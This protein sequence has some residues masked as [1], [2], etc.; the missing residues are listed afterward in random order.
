MSDGYYV[1]AIDPGEV[2]TGWAEWTGNEIAVGEWTNAETPDR[3]RAELELTRGQRRHVVIEAFRLYSTNA[4]EKVGDDMQTSQLIGV[5]KYIAG[6]E[7][8]PWTEQGA[9]IKKPTKRQLKARGYELSP[10]SIH[11]HDAELHLHYFLLKNKLIE[12]RQQ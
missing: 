4:L 11:A 12:G 3:L 1:I 2:H 7:L 9:D 6:L 10:G 8:V 5:I